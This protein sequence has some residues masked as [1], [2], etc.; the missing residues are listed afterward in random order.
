MMNDFD[1]TCFQEAIRTGSGTKNSTLKHYNR[2]RLQN[3]TEL[4]E[5]DEDLQPSS[6]LSTEDLPKNIPQKDY[7]ES[8]Q[9]SKRLRRKLLGLETIF[10]SIVLLIGTASCALCLWSFTGKPM[11]DFPYTAAII[12][13]LGLQA[14][15]WIIKCASPCSHGTA[16]SG[17]CII[18][19]GLSF[20]AAV[21][22]I[23]KNPN[24]DPQVKSEAPNVPPTIMI[25]PVIEKGSPQEEIVAIHN[26]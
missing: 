8:Q 9:R 12:V 23:K 13:A 20:V 10:A 4:N 24:K 25:L 21:G 1:H 16:I 2:I 15:P 26:Q 7:E 22:L 19:G 14:L 5:S 17:L 11:L 6:F 3:L 18:I